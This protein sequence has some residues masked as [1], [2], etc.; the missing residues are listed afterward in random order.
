[1][2]SF[3]KST[4]FDGLYKRFYAKDPTIKP[5]LKI[6]K[7][8]KQHSHPLPSDFQDHQLDP[9]FNG[10]AREC[11]LSSNVLLIYRENNSKVSLEMVVDHQMITRGSK[12]ESDIAKR[13][14]DEPPL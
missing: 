6:F 14:N 5:R 3:Q 10:Q 13:L 11:H 12:S 9:P 1:M 7:N 4:R 8:H 2:K